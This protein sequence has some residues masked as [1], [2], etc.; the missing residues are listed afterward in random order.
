VNA[1]LVGVLQLALL[2]HDVEE[3]VEYLEVGDSQ[4]LHDE[5]CHGVRF[6]L[7]VEF[8]VSV[9]GVSVDCESNLG[10]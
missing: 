8:D 3:Q 10:A 2:V 1:V 5:E 4:H 7:V 9:V 6:G